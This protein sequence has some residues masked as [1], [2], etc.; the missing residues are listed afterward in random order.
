LQL[1]QHALDYFDRIGIP[2][3][4]VL[5]ELFP[6]DDEPTA[7]AGNERLCPPERVARKDTRVLGPTEVDSDRLSRL[8]RSA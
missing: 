1:V 2:G 5:S 7:Q 8:G 6:R 4:A 3:G